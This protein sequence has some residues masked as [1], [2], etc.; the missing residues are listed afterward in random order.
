MRS[1]KATS[2]WR[3]WPKRK[4]APTHTSRAPSRATSTRRTNASAD[5]AASAASKRSSS[6][7]AMPA[8]AKPLSF[9]RRPDRRGTGVDEK[10]ARGKGSKL[11]TAGAQPSVCARAR[12]CASSA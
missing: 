10:Y 6:V 9:S 11:T 4:S 1:S 3:P 2:P 7:H 5:I 12:T 8:S